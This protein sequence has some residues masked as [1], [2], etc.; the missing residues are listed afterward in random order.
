MIILKLFSAHIFNRI[1]NVALVFI[2]VNK[3]ITSTPS[4][5]NKITD[6]YRVRLAVLH[7]VRAHQYTHFY[8][9]KH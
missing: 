9:I 1:N 6:W 5:F 3:F 2:I 4:L 7:N 8:Y